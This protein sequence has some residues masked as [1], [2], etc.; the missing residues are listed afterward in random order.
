MGLRVCLPGPSPVCGQPADTF[1]A[2]R[3]TAAEHLKEEQ[4]A[5]KTHPVFG[6]PPRQDF[7]HPTKALGR[8]PLCAPLGSRW[9]VLPAWRT[10]RAAPA[11]EDAPATSAFPR[12]LFC[13]STLHRCLSLLTH[14]LLFI[15][16]SSFCKFLAK[17]FDCQAQHPPESMMNLLSEVSEGAAMPPLNFRRKH[18]QSVGVMPWSR[19]LGLSSPQPHPRDLPL[20]LPPSSHLRS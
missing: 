6:H 8:S 4:F 2:P 1:P 9:W 11:L 17:N 13:E 7:L 15:T 10:P 19:C 16:N 5:V 3:P 18:S 14:S 12:T 20:P